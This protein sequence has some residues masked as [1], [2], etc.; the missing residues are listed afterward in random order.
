[1]YDD[2][3]KIFTAKCL[4]EGWVCLDLWDAVPQEHFTNSVI[5]LDEQGEGMLV[6]KLLETG[7]LDSN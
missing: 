7:I 5:H 2:Y 4:S 6:K 3:R 1:V